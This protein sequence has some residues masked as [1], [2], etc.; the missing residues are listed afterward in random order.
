[1]K[2]ALSAQFEQMLGDVDPADVNF[3]AAARAPQESAFDEAAEDEEM[4]AP[5]EKR[6]AARE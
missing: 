6:N 2:Q 3:E 4:A 5:V 1:M